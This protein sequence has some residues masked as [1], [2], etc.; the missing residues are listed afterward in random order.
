MTVHPSSPFWKDFFSAF[1]L[2]HVVEFTIHGAVGSV[3]KMMVTF[4]PDKQPL[5]NGLMR[6]TEIFEL[7]PFPLTTEMK[8]KLEMQRLGIS[9][10]H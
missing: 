9:R 3:V 2:N 5:K 7:T 8:N 10:I 4:Y 6:M 1:D